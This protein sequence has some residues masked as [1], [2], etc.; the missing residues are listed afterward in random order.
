MKLPFSSRTMMSLVTRSTWTLKVGFSCTAGT[1]AGGCA[2]AGAGACADSP[3][4]R[5]TSSAVDQKPFIF[6]AMGLKLYIAKGTPGGPRDEQGG[7]DAA[8]QTAQRNRLIGRVFRTSGRS[9]RRQRLSRNAPGVRRQKLARQRPDARQH[10]V[11][12]GNRREA[13]RIVQHVER[14]DRRQ[15]QQK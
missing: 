5:A 3:A 2:G 8:G 4:V 11:P 9:G 1:F 15:A 6:K 13:E 12:D 14:H 10:E 7:R